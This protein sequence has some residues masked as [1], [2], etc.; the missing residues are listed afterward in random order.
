MRRNESS[1][2]I[3]NINYLRNL[4]SPLPPHPLRISFWSRR[5]RKKENRN[6]NRKKIIERKKNEKK[7]IVPSRPIEETLLRNPSTTPRI[8]FW[9]RRQKRKIVRTKNEGGGGRV[10]GGGK[11]K[12]RSSQK[13]IFPFA[14]P[15][16]RNP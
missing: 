8:S 16:S 5:R 13:I 2:P 1:G 3:I 14:C 4:P 11:G 9:S 10:R 12:T 6:R 7:R 15:Y